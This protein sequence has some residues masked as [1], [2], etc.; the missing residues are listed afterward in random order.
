MAAI[1]GRWND[2]KPASEVLLAWPDVANR[3]NLFE[4]K[5]PSPFGI[6]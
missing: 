3:R 6:P 4:I 5:L 2:E 1:E